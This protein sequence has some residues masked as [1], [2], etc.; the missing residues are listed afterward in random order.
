MS[1]SR[2]MAA[3]R[4][5]K[6]INASEIPGFTCIARFSP[7]LLWSQPPLEPITLF[8]F[9]LS[10]CSVSLTTADYHRPLVTL[11]CLKDRVQRGPLLAP[12]LGHRT[13]E[14]QP[15]PQQRGRWSGCSGVIPP[16]REQQRF[17]RQPIRDQVLRRGRAQLGER[18]C[19]T[20][21]P[22]SHVGWYV[23]HPVAICQYGSLA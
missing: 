19:Q 10:L 9:P 1:M 15:R 20:N 8:L 3:Q 17:Q 16:Q 2:A 13:R 21:T 11:S 7:A 4:Q 22:K 5:N 6:A 14:L 12:Q 23:M 18:K